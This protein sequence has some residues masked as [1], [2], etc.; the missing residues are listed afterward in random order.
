MANYLLASPWGKTSLVFKQLAH[1]FSFL[2]SEICV[3]WILH[4]LKCICLYI[5]TTLV[6]VNRDLRHRSSLLHNSQLSRNIA[7]HPLLKC[8]ICHT[9]YS[10]YKRHM[11][12]KF[13]KKAH[14]SN[15][16]E[17]HPSILHGYDVGKCPSA[18]QSRT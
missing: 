17:I 7:A 16:K 10:P 8:H 6:S 12:I 18:E 15:Q 13:I 11:I 3:S 2:N 4:N 9:R 1:I 14:E 5:K